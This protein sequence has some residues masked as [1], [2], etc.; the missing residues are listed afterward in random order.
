MGTTQQINRNTIYHFLS[1]YGTVIFF[2]GMVSIF[3]ITLP[4][5]RSGFNLLNILSQISII[6]LISL[7]QTCVLKVGDFDLSIANIASMVCLII[8]TFLVKGMPIPLAIICALAAGTAV[9]V[10]NGL[11]VGYLGF[12]ALISTLAVGS[13][14]SGVSLI[15]SKGKAI[16]S[17]IPDEFSVIGQGRILGIPV[18]FL[19][20]IILYC[21]IWFIHNYTETGRKMEAIGGNLLAAHFSG[22]NIAWNRMIA[23]IFSGFC[24]SVMGLVIVSAS[25][26]ASMG[27]AD[28]YLLQ[29]LVTS[30]IGFATI[31]T[32]TFHVWGTLLGTLLITVAVN[33]LVISRVPGFYI[34]IVKGGI[35]LL[36]VMLGSIL[37]RRNK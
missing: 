2:T 12:P 3:S 17:G 14:I 26:R 23:F 10:I 32:G 28:S 31:K 6:A 27:Q 24:A 25:M 9:G 16:Y 13:I 18:R 29:S 21:I 35:L 34:D 5:F 36:A 4:A 8:A 22:I 1:R 37:G 30:F 33:G 7:G 19:I 20:M 11:L 15:A